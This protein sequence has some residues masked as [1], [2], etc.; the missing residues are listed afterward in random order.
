MVSSFGEDGDG[1]LQVVD[2]AAGSVSRPAA[3]R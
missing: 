1:E 3:V 2:D